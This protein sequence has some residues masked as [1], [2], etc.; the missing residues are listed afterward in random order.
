MSLVLSE[1]RNI[2]R[3]D[4]SEYN[5]KS[6]QEETRW[7]ILNLATYA[8]DHEVRLAARMVLDYISAH[9]AVS[10]NDLRRI[11]PFRRRNE[12]KNV[13]QTNGHM[14]IGIVDWSLGADT[15]VPYFAIQA[16]NIRVYQTPNQVGMDPDKP[17]N[18]VSNLP[19]R[20]WTFGIAVDP[21]D[22]TKEVLSSYRLPPLIHDLF[23]NDLHRR[24]FQR[25]HRTPQK[26]AEG[27]R[28]CDNYELY[29]G[30]P[31]YLITAGGQPATY[32]L[33]PYFFGV[34]LFGDQ[35]KGVAMPTTFM[36]T[37]QSAGPET[38]NLAE[39]L[40]QFSHFS[41]EFDYRDSSAESDYHGR[42]EF[43]NYGVAPDFACGYDLYLPR[44]AAGT[45]DPPILP[46]DP[47]GFHFKNRGSDGT[48]A[49][50]FLA[51]YTDRNYA[52]L[53]ALDTWLHPPAEILRR[54]ASL[55]FDVPSG[56]DA[57]DNVIDV[58]F[59]KFR[60]VVKAQNAGINLGV[61]DPESGGVELV[62]GGVYTT[63]YG[64]QI[65]FTI[66][67]AGA[68]TSNIV[69]S[70][71][72]PADSQ[73]D[74]GNVTGPFLNGTIMNSRR[75]AVVEISNPFYGPPG[76]MIILDLND[77]THPRRVS[78]TSEVEHAGY[79]NEVW[80][81]FGWK[82]PTEGDFFHPFNTLKA[83]VNAVAAGGVIKIVPGWTTERPTFTGKKRC[84]IV[85]PIGGVRIGVQ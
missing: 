77:L 28:N 23:V 11:V 52:L 4:F 85:A 17:M 36:P 61:R 33:D 76:T 74:A 41:A 64:T 35:Q 57:S 32:A 31:S 45:L 59:A 7:P 27:S 67:P 9:I 39:D 2:L 55:G 75:E 83:A 84:K 68:S 63:Y 58:A 42:P 43:L 14:A 65:R 82:G 66:G 49:G 8:Y 69:Y 46:S 30:S 60:E 54:A 13:K 78:E 19:V 16:G 10:S 34:P 12:G 37:G 48:S 40:I 26:E 15:V 71:V 20:P 51:I 29:A 50:F 79:N 21:H 47:P 72:H 3:D 44:W 70:N 5:A 73:G 81:N 56:A 25:L 24:F 1:L 22:V 38:Q 53:E 62:Q 6:Y 80:V 18:P